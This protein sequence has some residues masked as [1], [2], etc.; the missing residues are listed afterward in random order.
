MDRAAQNRAILIIC[1]SV[2]MMALDYSMLNI[3]LPAV[4]SRFG[5]DMSAIKWLPIIYMAI[6][7]MLFLVSGRLGDIRGHSKIF[8]WGLSIFTVGTFLCGFSANLAVLIAFRSFQAVGEAM[9]SPMSVAIIT[10][11]LPMGSR[12]K[13]L[14][15]LAMSQGVGFCAGPALGGF[16]NTHFGWQAI[17][18]VNVPIGIAVI[19]SAV[20]LLPA[21]TTA[22]SPERV[23]DFSFFR[24]MDFTYAFASAVLAISTV[25]GVSFMGPFYFEAARGIDISR[26]GFILTLPS[27]AMLV[28]APFSGWMADRFGGRPVCMAGMFLATL[29]FAAFSFVGSGTPMAHLVASFMLLGA[30][31]GVFVP[32]NNKLVMSLAPMDRQGAASGLYKIA[33]NLAGIAGIAAFTAAISRVPGNGAAAVEGAF[34]GAF[35][36]GVVI[37]SLAF[38]F[39]ALARDPAAVDKAWQL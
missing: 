13:A 4:A 10:T 7:T 27:L 29:S 16:L 32:A 14:G 12:G 23:F 15:F 24:N 35:F 3:S 2:F 22:A 30:A 25:V 33:L 9:Y 21:G 11:L 37:S 8:I 36:L 26:A 38:V 6:M 5:A 18:F 19:A 20:R 34:R 17:F 39:A 31:M 1:V 28:T